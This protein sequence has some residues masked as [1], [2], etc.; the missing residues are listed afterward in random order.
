M[1]DDK[2]VPIDCGIH[3]ELELACMRGLP[4][5]LTTETETL[6]G[7]PLTTRTSPD[8]A[9]WLVISLAGGNREIRMDHIRSVEPLNSGAGGTRIDFRQP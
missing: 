1:S 6:L 8:R 9:E 4:V 7:K 3:D 2:Y 5:K